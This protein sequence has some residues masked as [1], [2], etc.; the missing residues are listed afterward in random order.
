MPRHILPRPKLPKL[1]PKPYGTNL[2]STMGYPGSCQIKAETL[3]VSWWL[4]SVSW[5]E[6]KRYGPSPYHLQ[7]NRQ[8]ERFNSTLIAM[9]GMLPPEKKSEWKNH[10]GMLVHAYNCSQ[11]SATGFSPYYLMYVRQPCLPIDITLGLAPHTTTVPKHL[12]ICTKDERACKM[13]PE[14][15]FQAKEPQCHKKNYDKWRKA[16]ALEVGDMVLVCVTT[17]RAVTKSRTYG[18]IGN[19]VEKLSYPNVPV[20]VVC[21]RDGEGCNCTLH[22][23]YLLPINSNIGQNAPMAGVENNT[24]S[25]PAL[26]VDTEPSDA[27]PFGTVTSGVAG[28]TPHS[29]PDQPAP[30]R[31]GTWTAWNWLPWRYWNFGLLADT[32]PSNIWDA[33]VGLCTCLHVIS[34]L[35]TIFWGSTVW[36]RQWG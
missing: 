13:G 9:L 18:R 8:C 26:P 2:L 24:T 21:P 10:I 28:S 20:Y 22:R 23:N 30:L 7:T 19:F 4:T 29:S 12:K 15:A 1:L 14:K 3:R 6:H 5:W 11:N 17:L 35:Y 16:A 32:N 33:L 34:C 27:E 36:I 25:T 31:C